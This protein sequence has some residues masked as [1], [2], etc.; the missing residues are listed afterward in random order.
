MPTNEL[1]SKNDFYAGF[2][3]NKFFDPLTNHMRDLICTHIPDNT[4]V[5]DVGC[6]TGYQLLRM[7]SKIEKGVGVD[8]ADRMI[9]FARKQ[10]KRE[11]VD[12][13]MFDLASAA[14]LNQF[15]DNEFNLATMTLVLHEI[16]IELRV[17]ALKEMAR[18]SERQIIADWVVSPGLSRSAL[19]HLMEMTAG[20]SHYPSFRSYLKDDG[21]P[22][23]CRKTGLRII[24]EEA[25]FLGMA[26]IW[27]CE[28]E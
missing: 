1:V 24:R 18:V 21:V 20:I 5:L 14:D 15:D 10:Q 27:V 12:N 11:R 13:L 26:R 8:L 19:T 2:L 25:V 4:S 3:Y 16:E 17:P 28:K 23:L 9:S 22:G 6:G 7:A